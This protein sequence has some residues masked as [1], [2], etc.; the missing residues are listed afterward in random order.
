MI[1]DDSIIPAKRSLGSLRKTEKSKPRSP[2]F[3]G[4]MKLQR[5]TLDTVAK[6][7]QE[8]DAGTIDCCLAG[9]RNT[10]ANGQPYLSV[11]ISPKYIARPREPSNETLANFI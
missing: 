5:H 1:F 9:W 6:Q 2:D 11:E 4:T 10:D 8:T 7:F 3:T